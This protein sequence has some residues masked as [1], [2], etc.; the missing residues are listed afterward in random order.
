MSENQMLQKEASRSSKPTRIKKKFSARTLIF[1]S[2]PELSKQSRNGD[3]IANSITRSLP[4]SD[5]SVSPESSLHSELTQS[6]EVKLDLVSEA[7]GDSTSVNSMEAEIVI[8]LLRKAVSQVLNSPDMADSQSRKLLEALIDIVLEMLQTAPDEGDRITKLLH[9]KTRIV[10]VF[11]LLCI[12]ATAVTR[13]FSSGSQS[14]F[15]KPLPT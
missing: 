8:G 9:A 2:S 10:L 13:I 1:D 15:G 12:F 6:S 7:V 14:S 11:I 5:L 3:D 4:D